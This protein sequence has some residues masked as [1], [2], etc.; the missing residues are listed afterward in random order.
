[1]YLLFLLSGELFKALFYLTQ[2]LRAHLSSLQP[3]ESPLPHADWLG[4]PFPDFLNVPSF[5]V[6][7][8]PHS[9]LRFL[10]LSHYTGV[11]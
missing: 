4:F 8:H 7:Y 11:S 9:L 1:M 10:T 3:L 6:S 2:S 5:S